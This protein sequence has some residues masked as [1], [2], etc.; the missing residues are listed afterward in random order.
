LLPA[1]RPHEPVGFR[2]VEGPLPPSAPLEAEEPPFVE[3]C[4][5]PALPR[6]QLGAAADRPYFKR[7][8]ILPIPPE[9][10]KAEASR[11]AGLPEGL[12]GHNH[13]PGL[14]VMPNGDLLAV[15]FTSDGY[16]DNRRDRTC[17]SGEA[18]PDIALMAVRLRYGSEQW[19]MPEI[20]L[21][22]PDINDVAALLWNDGG[23]V[24]LFWG[25]YL[26][27]VPFRTA[28]SRDSGASWQDL[29][30]VFP[31]GAAGPFGAG[32]PINSAFRTPD[33]TLHVAT[34]GLGNDSVL[35]RSGDDGRTWQDP[36]GRTGGRH[37][38]CVPLR[39]GGILCLGGKGTNIDGYLPISLSR[40]GGQTWQVTRGPFPALGGNQRP[41]LIRLASGRLFYA[42]EDR[43]IRGKRPAD[44]PETAPFVALSEDEGRTWRRRPLPGTLPHE[45]S[46]TLPATLGYSVA[47]Q[48]PDGVIHLIT[49][50]TDPSQHF[51]LNEAWVLARDAHAASEAGAGSAGPIVR[52][53]V[54]HA[55]RSV[56]ATWSGRVGA[57][58]RYRLHGTTTWFY[59]GGREQWQAEYRDGVKSGRETYWSPGGQRLWSWEHRPDGTSMWT[60]WW[61]EG[62]KRSESTWRNSRAVGQAT[63]WDRSGKVV[64][65]GYFDDGR[66]RRP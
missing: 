63:R 25:G 44:F 49:S 20:L 1:F 4:V 52:E 55:D 8:P 38:T 23:T 6:V 41:T 31:T 51:E 56:R 11:A 7:R 18:T 17:V 40:D 30:F 32:Q 65:S 14:E 48:A 13:S 26:D 34:D 62:G 12:L 61:P 42:G 2:V 15:Y 29:R 9:N 57:D 22:Y 53:R 24:R 3:Q 35:W 45:T 10:V 28:L 58:G 39:D 19:D 36:G 33:G 47:R 50:M 27:G 37:S 46:A 5:K 21:D 59:P 16:E 60:R 54:L 66:L 64:S 43:D